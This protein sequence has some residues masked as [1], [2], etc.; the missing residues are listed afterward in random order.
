[1]IPGELARHHPL[2]DR[3]DE[4]SWALEL[5]FG[6]EYHLCPGTIG[7]QGPGSVDRLRALDDMHMKARRP[8]ELREL[9][10]LLELLYPGGFVRS[11]TRVPNP[12]EPSESCCT[13]VFDV[14]QSR[15]FVGFVMSSKTASGDAATTNDSTNLTA[16]RCST[17]HSTTPSEPP[18]TRRWH[19]RERTASHRASAPAR[20]RAS[21]RRS[22]VRPPP[23]LRS[24][25]AEIRLSRRCLSGTATSALMS[26]P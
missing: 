18:S 20:K 22:C 15:R 6:H 1:V 4:P 8:I 2:D 10:D 13:D 26:M 17:A 14:C 12:G 24:R 19:H 23:G 5:T 7:L 9:D 25:K 11:R 3:S 16:L 21:A